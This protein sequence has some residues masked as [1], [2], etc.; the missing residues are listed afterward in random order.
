MIKYKEKIL[1]YTIVVAVGLGGLVLLL[2]IFN[3]I[4]YSGG[5]FSMDSRGGY[6][7]GF[8]TQSSSR[9]P[10]HQSSDLYY[11]DVYFDNMVSSAPS[12]GRILPT[13]QGPST[14]SFTR[15]QAYETTDYTVSASLRSIDTLCNQ[16]EFLRADENT[17]FRSLT[18][19]EQS[20]RA[21]FF[22]EENQVDQ[23]LQ[24]FNSIRGVQIDRNTHS[25][26]TLREQVTSE[27]DSLRTQLARL[28]TTISEAEVGFD[29]AIAFARTESDATALAQAVNEKTNTLNNLYQQQLFLNAQI[30]EV[31]RRSQDLN[32]RIGLVGF[33]IRFTS[34]TRANTNRQDR[35]W[36]HAIEILED[37][38]ID[39]Q[40]GVTIGLFIVLLWIIQITIYGVLLF[41]ILFGLW[42]VYKRFRHHH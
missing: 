31:A 7:D 25:V 15:L 26:T 14:G 29:E 32:E 6:S 38:L 16:L 21:H 30:Q 4:F 42:K 9:M 19:N 17:Q 39:F 1:R 28:E 3:S 37:R 20:C 34:L 8:S 2:G 40:T 27:L 36:A 23:L 11:D 22:V 41:I 13:P 5:G 35:A 18:R 24:Y 33:S 12:Q 10:S